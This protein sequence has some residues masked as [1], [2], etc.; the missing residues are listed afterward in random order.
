MYV[1]APYMEWAKRHPRAAWDLTGSNLLPCTLDDLPEA[2]DALELW[3]PNDEGYVPLVEAIA[4][5]A[6]V[7]VDRVALA[8]GASGANYLVCAALLDRGD[9][10]LIERP[11]YDPLVAAAAMQGAR[12]LR[13]DR[14]FED[15]FALD[16]DAVRAAITPR[17]RLVIVTNSHN[18][19]GVVA[20]H[21]ALAE[22]GRIAAASGAR[23]LVDEVY[24]DAA[25]LPGETSAAS[26]SEEFISTNSLTKAY[27]LAGLRCGWVIAAPDVAHRVRRTRDVVD[28]AGAFPAERIAA[29]AFAHLDRLK[30]RARGILAANGAAV[31]AFLRGRPEIEWIDPPA[32]SIVFPRL[33][34]AED[35]EPFVRRLLGEY[36]TAI[37]PGRFFEAP[38][39][40][41]IAFGGAPNI[42]AGG[43]QRI[44]LA[45]DTLDSA[46]LRSRPT[47]SGEG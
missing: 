17:T 10:V 34:G 46:A 28:G 11:G 19:S 37:V 6:G 4:R 5:H 45:L 22:T 18:P 26:R 15:G 35:A 43:L 20:S 27:G 13:F 29:T 8:T 38:A 31:R 32:G 7:S 44:G 42:L 2:R 25:C 47:R 36:Q 23:V 14:R 9:D 24:L 41:R 1:S 30:M 40:F 16:P 33:R 21:E 3:G 12:L 39:H